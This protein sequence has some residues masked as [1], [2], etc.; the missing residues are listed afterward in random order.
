MPFE[1]DVVAQRFFASTLFS[2][3]SAQVPVPASRPN[4]SLDS[5]CFCDQCYSVGHTQNRLE[6]KMTGFTF[7]QPAA[8]R[9]TNELTVA[10]HDRSAYGHD[11][12]ASLDFPAFESAVVDRHLLRIR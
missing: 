10:D 7:D 3:V 11:V 12:R 5:L 6:S 2:A 8:S 4:L 1:R 9:R